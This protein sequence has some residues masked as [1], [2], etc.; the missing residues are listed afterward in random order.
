MKLLKNESIGVIGIYKTRSLE[1]YERLLEPH[2]GVIASVYDEGDYL[3]VDTMDGGNDSVDIVKVN[4]HK[5]QMAFDIERLI[6]I[7]NPEIA[8]GISD[9]D[10][11]IVY[12]ITVSETHNYRYEDKKE[13]DRDAE[14][15]RDLFDVEEIGCAEC[16]GIGFFANGR[17]STCPACN[18]YGTDAS[19]KEAV[20]RLL[21]RSLP[22]VVKA[23]LVSTVITTRVVTDETDEE[24]I[25]DLAKAN[26]FRNMEADWRE[27]IEIDGDFEVPYEDECEVCGGKGYVLSNDA[28]G[29]PQIQRCDSCALF[30]TDAD[31]LRYFEDNPTFHN[32]NVGGI[33]WRHNGN[34]EQDVVVSR[35]A[36]EDN[37]ND[38]EGQWVLTV[39]TVN[40]SFVFFYDDKTERDEDAA[41]FSILLRVPVRSY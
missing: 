17:V 18:V 28:H 15:L 23:Y 38:L 37:K 22:A 35:Y 4:F 2:F 36:D 32:P 21:R 33:A 26:L 40:D 5:N 1:E 9:D 34:V 25:I 20:S 24:K 3:S 16:G 12:E 11:G 19:A 27:N 30:A 39:L 10:N 13:R 7:E 14:T 41:K 8:F 6:D 31:A 29:N